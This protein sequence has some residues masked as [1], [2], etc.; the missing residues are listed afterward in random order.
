[1]LINCSAKDIIA[2][3]E[4][5]YRASVV[6]NTPPIVIYGFSTTFT[7]GLVNFNANGNERYPN[8]NE[9]Y[10][11]DSEGYPNDSERY[12]NDNGR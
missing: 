3:T 8:V 11:N 2:T 7:E 4:T 12:A 10:A 5:G 1:M 9:R 6:I